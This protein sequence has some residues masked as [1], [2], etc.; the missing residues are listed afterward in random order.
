MRPKDL[1][2]SGFRAIGT[3]DLYDRDDG[4]GYCPTGDNRRYTGNLWHCGHT[5]APSWA[6]CARG[7]VDHDSVSD[8]TGAFCVGRP[9]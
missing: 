6:G 5:Y 1:G 7:T 8:V 4:V 2:P 9:R 3:T